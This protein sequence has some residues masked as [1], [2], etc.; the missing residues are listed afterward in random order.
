M[1]KLFSSSQ[2]K[3]ELKIDKLKYKSG[4]TVRGKLVMFINGKKDVKARSF[5]FIVKAKEN[6]QINSR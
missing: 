3:M 4:E 1:I 5:R 2:E 6:N